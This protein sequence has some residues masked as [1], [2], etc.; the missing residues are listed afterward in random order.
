MSPYPPVIGS[1]E[2]GQIGTGKPGDVRQPMRMQSKLLG[3][4]VS[5][6]CGYYHTALVTKK[7]QLFVFGE[8]DEGVECALLLCCQYVLV[9]SRTPDAYLYIINIATRIS[10]H[11][12]ALADGCNPMVQALHMNVCICVR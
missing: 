11:N 12:I 6:S 5:V 2:C 9:R 10:E 4:V 1:N 3:E 7:G 8:A